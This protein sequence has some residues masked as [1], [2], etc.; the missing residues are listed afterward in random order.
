MKRLI[1]VKKMVS[2]AVV[3]L[4][5]LGIT[6]CPLENHTAEK[7]ASFSEA[8]ES[9]NVSE[10][11][12][13]IKDGVDKKEITDALFVVS[14][15]GSINMAKLL[16]KAGADVNTEDDNGT[17][18]L[19]I[20]AFS[21]NADV[22]KQLIKSGADVNIEDEGVFG[23]ALMAAIGNADVMA[24]LYGK[25]NTDRV[26]LNDNI[27]VIEQLIKAGADVNAKKELDGT[28]ALMGAAAFGNIDAV[29]LL[30]DAG[31]DI[32]A[33]SRYDATAFMLAEEEGHDNIVQLLKEAGADKISEQTEVFAGAEQMTDKFI[34]NGTYIKI[35]DE[36]GI[37]YAIKSSINYVEINKY[38]VSVNWG[39]NSGRFNVNK[40]SISL[41]KSNNLIIKLKK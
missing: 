41:D 8:V 33:K 20:A 7:A 6:A 28:T 34:K 15:K 1:R 29:K 12:R 27:D 21:G 26:I 37:S 24:Q 11:K 2:V 35:Y 3:C 25:E 40:Y 10:A 19:M 5:I 22:V 39:V 36:D 9:N 16:L 30:I 14:D 4:A 38:G 23:T 17:T 18:V 13:F 31:A 32:N